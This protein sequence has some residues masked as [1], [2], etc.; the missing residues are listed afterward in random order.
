[1]LNYLLS[2][3]SAL[4][5]GNVGTI[6]T[7]LL[8]EETGVGRLWVRWDCRYLF[9]KIFDAGEVVVEEACLEFCS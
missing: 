4:D 6:L 8:V 5:V 1:M 7:I 9:S 2:Y 3:K